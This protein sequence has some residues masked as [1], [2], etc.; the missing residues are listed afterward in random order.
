[1]NPWTQ[2]W[3]CILYCCSPWRLSWAPQTAWKQGLEVYVHRNCRMWKPCYSWQTALNVNTFSLAATSLEG[4]V[5]ILRR[6]ASLGMS[7]QHDRHK[8]MPLI[9]IFQ[10]CDIYKCLVHLTTRCHLWSIQSMSLSTHPMQTWKPLASDQ[11]LF[12]VIAQYEQWLTQKV[13]ARAQ[14]YLYL[15]R[16]GTSMEFNVACTIT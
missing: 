16:L 11:A 10:Q 13:G 3:K 14:D 15:Y 7:V 9:D 2:G 5:A 1:M 8:K 12:S 4:V 6:F